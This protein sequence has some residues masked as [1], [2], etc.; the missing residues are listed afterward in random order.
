MASSKKSKTGKYLQFKISIF[1]MGKTII[2]MGD[3]NE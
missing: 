1:L 2:T 3:K